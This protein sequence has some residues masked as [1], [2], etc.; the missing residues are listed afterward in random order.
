MELL[1]LNAQKY[2]IGRAA[3]FGV[4]GGWNGTDPLFDEYGPMQHY[5]TIEGVV[6]PEP[7]PEYSELTIE[8]TGPA[9][10]K[11]YLSGLRP[12][13]D[14][15]FFPNPDNMALLSPTGRAS[16]GQQRRTLVYEHT[17]WI[18]PEELFLKRDAN[19]TVREVSVYYDGSDWYK[20]GVAVV[21]GSED[22]RLIESSMV[23]WRA[24]FSPLTPV[25]NH[26]DGG[27]ALKA[28]TVTVQQDFSKPDG[29]QLYLVMAELGDFP[30]LDLNPSS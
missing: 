14:V 28:T 25:F 16:Q 30:T 22:E 8:T 26:E 20:D 24:D 13:F 17:L 5:G 12:T 11:R 3:I 15:N 6:D 1:S 29:C 21:G 23:I 7:N 9:A 2:D 27:K 19:G 10:L 4:P 18:V